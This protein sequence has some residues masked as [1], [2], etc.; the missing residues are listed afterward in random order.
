M[1]YAYGLV[2]MAKNNV[3]PTIS[4]V[5]TSYTGTR[6]IGVDTDNSGNLSYFSST[7]TDVSILQN[8]AVP[9]H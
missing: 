6:I 2:V 1:F 8:L 4:V 7:G 3:S 9:P 5:Y